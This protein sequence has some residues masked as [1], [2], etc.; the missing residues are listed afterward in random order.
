[1]EKADLAFGRGFL[2]RLFP[3]SKRSFFKRM[4]LVRDYAW[5]REEMRDRSTRTYYLIRKYTT[6]IARRWVD[7]G[8][9]NEDKD[10]FF[11]KFRQVFDVLEGRIGQE[12]ADQIIRNNKDYYASFRNFRN[13]NEIGS[14]WKIR[15]EVR[16]GLGRHQGLQ[17]IGCSPGATR[18]RAKVI[19]DISE[20]HRLEQD[21]ILVTFFTDPGWTPVLNLVS[22]VVTETGG[23]LSH[24]AI[25]A[26]E[27]G[28][29]AVLNVRDATTL[30]KD[31][32]TIE[33]DGDKGEI[34]I[35]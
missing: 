13:P 18:G 30:L 15:E 3:F 29:P 17:G 22:A 23:L 16:K 32:Q 2:A 9:I 1:V 7:E 24:A 31:N 28:I 8:R 25:I 21:D 14:R 27:Y 34:R 4:R 6:E 5:W 33:V 20:I 19:R 26:R 12:E 11:L 10:I 35:V